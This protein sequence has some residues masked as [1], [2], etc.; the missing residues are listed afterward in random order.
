MPAGA[1]TII[2][3]EWDFDGSGAFASRQDG[4]DGTSSTITGRT[5]TSY[6]KP[7]TYFVS[8]RV[9]SHRDGDVAATARRIENL[10][11]ARVVVS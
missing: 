1:G 10:A 3:L 6:D 5:T 4:I 9:V 8:A 11:S 2:A 7:G